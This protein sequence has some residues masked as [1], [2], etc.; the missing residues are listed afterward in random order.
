VFKSLVHGEK[1]S[2]EVLKQL[3]KIHMTADKYNLVAI[4][5]G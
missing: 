1:A 5:R 4:I 2:G 3:E